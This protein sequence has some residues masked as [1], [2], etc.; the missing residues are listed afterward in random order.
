[1]KTI[2]HNNPLA[3]SNIFPADFQAAYRTRPAWITP[4]ASMLPPEVTA[5]RLHFKLPE[6]AVIRAHVSADV[7]YQLFLDGQ[8]VGRGPER[9]SNQAWFYETYNLD[10]SSGAHTL[11]VL[12]W[13]LGEIGPLAQIGLTGGFL[14]EAEGH[15]ANRFPLNQQPG[16][17]NRWMGSA[18]ANPNYLEWERLGLLSRSRRQMAQPT[19][20]AWK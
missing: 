12:V 17:P 2:S 16:R 9:G 8:R 6:A 11:T 5:Y 7:R 10:L 19:L 14:L 3:P 20:G 18:S 4:P 1:M 15:T 13:R